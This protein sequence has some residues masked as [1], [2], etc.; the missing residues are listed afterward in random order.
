MLSSGI[1]SR[2]LFEKLNK[3]IT[4]FTLRFKNS[5]F[6]ESEKVKEICKQKV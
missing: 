6:D 4:P 3:N 2:I 1:D 5:Q